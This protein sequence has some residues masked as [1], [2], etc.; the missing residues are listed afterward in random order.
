[1]GAMSTTEGPRV[2]GRTGSKAFLPVA[3]S[4]S[5]SFVSDMVGVACEARFIDDG[6]S[7]GALHGPAR[8]SRQRRRNYCAAVCN[9]STTLKSCPAA[10]FLF[11]YIAL[12]SSRV[13][14]LKAGSGMS[15]AYSDSVVLSVAF[16]TLIL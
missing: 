11:G 6:E 15:A 2:P 7:S 9:Y 10:G 5:S 12:M 4:S 13:S 14:F 16:T 3:E 8:E 1:M